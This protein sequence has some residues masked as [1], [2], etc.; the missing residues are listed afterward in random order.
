[1]SIN[2][3]GNG[4][5]EPW[6]S[7]TRRYQNVQKASVQ[8]TQQQYVSQYNNECTDGVD[9]GKISIWDKIK[10]IGKGIISSVGNMVKGIVSNPVKSAAI[11]GVCCIPVVGKFIGLGLA[12][13]G[14]IKSGSQLIQNIQTADATT[15]DVEAKDAWQNIGTNGFNLALSAAAAK[16]CVKGIKSDLNGGSATVNL[17]RNLKNSKAAKAETYSQVA[18][19]AARETA[20]NIVA[21]PKA[22]YNKIKNAGKRAYDF[23]TAN[24]GETFTET[25]R[26]I[27]KTGKKA[28]ANKYN[29]AVENIS[30]KLGKKAEA[31]GKKADVRAQKTAQKNTN[32]TKAAKPSKEQVKANA[33]ATAEKVE[34][35][36]ENAKTAG[37]EVNERIGGRFETIE[38]KTLA[39]G[40]TFKE[41][42]LYDKS[43]NRLNTTTY[44]N[45]TITSIQGSNGKFVSQPK[46]IYSRQKVQ[47]GK[48]TAPVTYRQAAELTPYIVIG[49]DEQ[50]Q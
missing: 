49:N 47:F 50:N 40:R 27:L 21:I 17:A 44:V 13:Y 33:K 43:G 22:A 25:A 2:S 19:S 3:V 12:A 9:D 26:N 24:K 46:T 4:Y 14:T 8:K 48:L 36:K 6:Y 15:S 32:K 29:S 42:K 35:I 20:G 10:G 23:Y 28:V 31:I 41:V 5:G 18:Q 30:N 1:M 37:A 16:G 45:D 7:T 11:I 38:T 34:T 39:D